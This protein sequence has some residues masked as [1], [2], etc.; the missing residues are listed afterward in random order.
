MKLIYIKNNFYLITDDFNEDMPKGRPYY[1]GRGEIRVWGTGNI[2][3]IG[4]KNI[5]ASTNR[6]ESLPRLDYNQIVN[7]LEIPNQN[8]FTLNEMIIF[9]EYFRNNP[10]LCRK[11]GLL[12]DTRE[13]EHFIKLVIKRQN[14][15]NVNALYRVKSGS[16]IEHEQGLAGYEWYHIFKIE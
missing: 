4:A 12:S 7:E 1:D 13:T 15:W 16:M 8:T 3:S 14:E 11:K 6:K 10:H 2:Y 5:I 9:G